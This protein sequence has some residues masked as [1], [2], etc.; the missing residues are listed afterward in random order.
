MFFSFNNKDKLGDYNGA[1][2]AEFIEITI[3]IQKKANLLKHLILDWFL[4][5]IIELNPTKR[6]TT[7]TSCNRVNLLKNR[8]LFLTLF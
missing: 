4:K 6:P 5:Q 7:V 3:R 2:K 8:L 1:I